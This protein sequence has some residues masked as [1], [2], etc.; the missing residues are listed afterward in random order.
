MTPGAARLHG[1]RGCVALAAAFVATLWAADAAAQSWNL[2]RG[3][4][5]RIP[6]LEELSRPR[7]PRAFIPP[8]QATEAGAPLSRF[9]NDSTLRHG[10]V[11]M[12]DDGPMRFLGR[13]GLSHKAEDFTR[14]EARAAQQQRPRT[15]KPATDR[16]RADRSIDAPV[17]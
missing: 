5:V 13:E 10:D 2:E 16:A 1:L 9:L 7:A 12:T 15:T 6:S 3:G 4:P 17:D 11:V 8:P 14:V